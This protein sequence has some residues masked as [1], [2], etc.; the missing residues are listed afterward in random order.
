MDRT[1]DIVNPV[2][3]RPERGVN[4]WATGMLCIRLSTRSCSG[5]SHAVG[6]AHKFTGLRLMRRAAAHVPTNTLR[7]TFLRPGLENEHDHDNRWDNFK[8]VRG[9]VALRVRE[10][11]RRTCEIFEIRILKGVVNK[12]HVHVLVSVPL[13]DS[14]K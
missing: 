2:G 14:A 11:V 6:L 5:R 9:D 12:D 4:H 1:V 8:V 10:L 7:L 3:E 13:N